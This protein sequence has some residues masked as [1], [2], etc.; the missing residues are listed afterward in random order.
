MFNAPKTISHIENQDQEWRSYQSQ[1]YSILKGLLEDGIA[2]GE[3][4][5]LDPNLMFKAIGGLFVGLIFM[6]EK[7]KDVSTR[8]IEK[9]L[10]NLI[11]EPKN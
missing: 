5:K 9:L 11:T 1:L 8:D 6:G 3:F 10:N 7:N 4:P 2:K